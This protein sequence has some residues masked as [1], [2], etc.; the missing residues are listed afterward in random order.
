MVERY[1]VFLSHNGSDTAAVEMIA[2]RLRNEAQLQPFL[3]K[4]HLVVGESWIPALERAIEASKT[5]AVFFGPA[6]VSAWQAEE[7]QLGLVRSVQEEKRRVI[8][9]LL[10]GARKASVVGF[11][12]LRSFIDL[13][14]DDGFAKLV[15]AVG[16]LSQELLAAFEPG[17]DLVRWLGVLARVQ[18]EIIDFS[19]ERGRHTC[20]FGREDVLGEIDAWLLARDSGWFLV[21]GSPGLGKSALLDRWLRRRQAAGQR[22]AFHFIRRGHLDWAE[23]QV[24]QR[25]LAAQIEVM[26]PEQ[27]DPDADPVY[28]LEQLLGRVSRV[29]VERDERLVLLVDGLDEAMMAGKDNPIPYIFPLEV[30]GRVLVFTASRPQYPHLGWFDRRNGPSSRLDLD[31]RAESNERAVREYWGVLGKAMQP[32]LS[33]ALIR[34]AVEGAQG[35]LLHA[36]KLRQLWS[37]AEAERSVDAVPRGLEGMLGELWR[38]IEELPREQRKLARQGLSLVCAARESLPL[39]V[40]GKLLGWDEG[41]ARADLLPLVRE[42]LLEEPWNEEPAYRPFHERLREVVEEQLVEMIGEHRRMLAEYASWPVE[43]DEF[44]RG[45]ALRHRVEHLVEAELFDE[46][47]KAC[48]DVGYLTAKARAEGVVAF[49]RDIRLATEACE[50]GKASGHLMTLGHLVAACAH[51]AAEVPEALPALLHDRTLTNAPELIDDLRDPTRSS[52]QHPRLRHPLQVRGMSRILPGHTGVVTAVA[53]LPDGR[54]VSGSSDNTLR[55]WDVQSGR[56]LAILQ[57]HSGVVNAVAVLPDGCLVSGSSDRTLRVWDVQSGR[58]LA[59]LQGHSSWVKAVAVLPDG[60]LVSGSDDKTLRVWD[61]QSGRTL[62]TLEGHE[63]AVNAVAVLPDGYLVSGSDDRRLRVWNV[64]SGRAFATLRGHS[65]PVRAVAVLPDGRLVS[66]SDDNTLR[67]WDVQSGRT[68]ATFQG[69]TSWVRAVAVLPDGRVVSGSTDQTLQVWDV[70]SERTLT[71]L[72][73]HSDP[74]RAVAVL[75]DGRLVSGSDDKTLRVW[76]VQS[77]RTSTLQAHSDPVRAMV[78]LPDGRLSGST[79]DRL[80]VWDVHSGQVLQTLRMWDGQLRPDLTN[81]RHSGPVRA[82][83]VQPDGRLVSGSYDGEVRVWD[84]TTEKTLG[85]LGGRSVPVNAVAVLSDGRL[86]S[87]S[88]D[89]TVRVWE[90]TPQKIATQTGHLPLKNAKAVRIWNVCWDKPT[91]GD[92]FFDWELM[93]VTLTT[94]EGHTGPVRAI[95]VLP[96]GCVVSGSDDTTLRV[97][98][99][100]TAQTVATL[101]GHESSVVAVAALSD[102]RVASGSHDGLVAVWNVEKKTATVLSGHK[103]LVHAVAA[104]PDGRVISGSD[105]KTLRIWD[106]PTER[107]LATVYGDASFLSVVCVDQHLIV[108]GDAL[109][110]VWFIDLPDLG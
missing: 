26:F 15:T 81:S 68:L 92:D 56:T 2:L 57:G 64:Q 49:E 41:D 34:A 98:D 91:K 27:R 1:D 80:R 52:I 14:E 33:D 105:D 73:G 74:V 28:R 66:G 22:T 90:V 84:V 88:D 108:A 103:S 100:E 109:G 96:N 99:V 40:V 46:A 31:A 20:F 85:T 42:M 45:Y 69:H 61:V 59:T 21:T 50:D 11:L 39:R 12:R 60:R 102:G 6:G 5:V 19:N 47:A 48:M 71:T 82:L 37:A 24:V 3:D 89:K 77:E 38:R 86:V 25:N 76:D 10:P 54:L 97:W 7:A 101:Q 67:V 8:P 70:Q 17:P 110:N 78:V 4:W 55:V 44:R 53:V 51:W 65:D 58:T 62:A 106:V 43:G 104:L 35:N 16:G 94:L 63:G 36:V 18:R 23:P 93:M 95:A 87:G 29:L 13:G 30:P 75:P 72:R 107:T 83:A 79:D 9:V 32:P